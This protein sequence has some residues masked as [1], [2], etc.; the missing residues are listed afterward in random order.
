MA[1]PQSEVRLKD[2]TD[3]GLNCASCSYCMVKRKIMHLNHG[4]PSF[5]TGVV[6]HL[7]QHYGKKMTVTYLKQLAWKACT[8][9]PDFEL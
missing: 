1:M 5:K 4:L 9:N 2:K 8:P 7:L 6:L 3:V